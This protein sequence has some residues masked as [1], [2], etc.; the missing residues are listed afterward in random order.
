MHEGRLKYKRVLLVQVLEGRPYWILKIAHVAGT[1]R[2]PWGTI[3]CDIHDEWRD[4]N[5]DKMTE[6]QRPEK[7]RP[8]MISFA[9]ANYSHLTIQVSE[10]RWTG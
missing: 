2:S 9:P 10:S 1:G 3:R 4:L 6:S 8:R 7:L 5:I